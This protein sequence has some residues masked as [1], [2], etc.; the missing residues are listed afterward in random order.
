MDRKKP[1]H[2][3]PAELPKYERSLYPFIFVCTM[4]ILKQ[5][6]FIFYVLQIKDIGPWS[7]HKN[8]LKNNNSLLKVG[9]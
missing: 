2:L 9:H 8:T 3:S 6:D 4:H 5:F 1:I 7:N